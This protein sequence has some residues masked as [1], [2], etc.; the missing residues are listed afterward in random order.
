MAY[1]TSDIADCAAYIRSDGLVAFPTETVYGL[2]ANALSDSAVRSIFQAKKRPLN[3]PV[4]VHVSGLEEALGLIAETDPGILN[5][6]RYLGGRFWPGPLTIVCKAAPHMP[7]VLM[8]GTGYVGVRCP[9]HPIALE[10]IRTSGVPIAAPSAN[11]FSH[12]SPTSPE[13][14]LKDFAQSEYQIKVIPGGQCSFGI[15]STVVKLYKDTQYHLHILRKGGVSEEGLRKALA[16]GGIEAEVSAVSREHHISVTEQAEGPGQLLKHYSPAIDTYIA[17]T[18]K[19]SNTPICRLSE[20][21]ILDFH[22][23][24]SSLQAQYRRNLSESGDI[25][26]AINNLYAALRWTEELPGVTCVLLPDLRSV[27][28]SEFV[29]SLW[30]RIYRAAA[31]REAVCVGGEVHTVG[32]T[33]AID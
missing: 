2:G 9:N 25:A 15:E 27:T 21:V 24:M 14:V 16:E 32:L 26:E 30:D 6:Y 18:N 4:I 19:P 10:L 31:G 23:M 3:D 17:V 28:Q 20:A 5:I 12:V 1:L 7:A 29:A 11:L 13:H 33:H 22:S 8:A